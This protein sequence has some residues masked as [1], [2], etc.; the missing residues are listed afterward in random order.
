MWQDQTATTYSINCPPGT[1][2]NDCGMGPG[3][4]VVAGK[5]VTSWIFDDGPALYV[6]SLS[7]RSHLT[8]YSIY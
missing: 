4:T 8:S 1:D 7:L 6:A 5:D 2:S 3:M